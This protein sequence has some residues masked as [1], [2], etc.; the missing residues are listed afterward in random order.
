MRWAGANVEDWTREATDFLSYL[1]ETLLDM[2]ITARE[3]RTQ[4]ILT[5]SVIEEA[6]RSAWSRLVGGGEIDLTLLRSRVLE[7]V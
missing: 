2:S 5:L 1:D 3:A 4:K 7:A 6:I